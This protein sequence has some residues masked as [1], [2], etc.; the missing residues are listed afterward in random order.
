MEG[1]AV[2][3]PMDGDA[4]IIKRRLMIKPGQRKQTAI[5]FS[6]QDEG[7]NPAGFMNGKVEKRRPCPAPKIN[8][9]GV[10]KLGCIGWLIHS[11]L[12]FCS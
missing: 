1:M 2:M 5:P 3:G 12:P 6:R 4:I 7:R 11:L 8:G 9:Y 10:Y